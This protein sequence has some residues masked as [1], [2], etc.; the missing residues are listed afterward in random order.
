MGCG[1]STAQDKEE[2]ARNDEIEGQ[3]KK[4]KLALKCEVKM[5]LL[6]NF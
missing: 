1:A 5:L 2:K 3:L 6:G 4:D